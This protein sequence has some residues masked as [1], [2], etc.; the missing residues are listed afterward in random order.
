M[1]HTPGQWKFY[2]ADYQR[3]PGDIGPVFVVGP[4]EFHTVATIRAGNEDDDLPAQTEA[5]ARLIAAAPVMLASAE[6]FD[7]LSLVIESAARN[8][9]PVNPSACARIVA[10]IMANRAAIRSAKGES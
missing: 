1:T 7:R 5:N 3:G 10:A 9:H 6:E 2:E 8:E 4:H